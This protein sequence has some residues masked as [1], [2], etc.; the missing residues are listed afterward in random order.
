MR[1]SKIYPTEAQASA[2]AAAA[3]IYVERGLAKVTLGTTTGD[4]KTVADGTYASDKVTIKNWALDVTN[5]K[6]FP[7]HNV[8]GLSTDYED[9]WV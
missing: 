1:L 3:D 2:G 5:E 7:I 8:D 6:T 9:I 4:A